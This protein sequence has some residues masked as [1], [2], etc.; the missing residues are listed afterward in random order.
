M[1]R[2]RIAIVTLLGLVLAGL[3]Y[4]ALWRHSAAAS[5]LLEASGTIETTEVDVSFQLAGKV[6]SLLVREGDRVRAGQ[7][8]ARLDPKPLRE[9]L[10]RTRAQL[11]AAR[12][13]IPQLR[14]MIQW[15]RT[16]VAEREQ[17][18]RAAVEAAAARAREV[19]AGA[20]TQELRQAESALESAEAALAK[21]KLDRERAAELVRRKVYSQAA[22]DAAE[23]AYVAARSQRDR[24]A[25][26][27]ALLREGSRR[28]Q[29]ESAEASLRQA[30]YQ[31]AQ[32]QSDRMQ[33][34]MRQQDLDAAQAREQELQAALNLARLNLEYAEL[35]S[36]LAGSVLLRSIEAGEVV[37]VGT[38]VVT[39]GDL[40]DLWM[41]VYVGERAVGRL[42]LSDPVE[43]R[44]DAHGPESFGGRIIFIS[45]EAEFTPRNI[46]TK[47]ER[48]KLVYRVKVAIRNRDGKLKPGMPADATLRLQT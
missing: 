38:P 7:V 8:L 21:A 17:A 13:A 30:R 15:T 24:A 19:R 23:A 45:R 44:V 5:G 34:D 43:V 3:G 18:A 39:V 9:N 4:W 11:E 1:N 33:V 32:V 31:L 29:I 27:L 26:S 14:S 6:E 36:P 16:T 37:N 12:A 35:K 2:Q 10:E 22:L 40:D 28:E 20:R 46:Q 47:E 48:T 41:N 25:E 42:R